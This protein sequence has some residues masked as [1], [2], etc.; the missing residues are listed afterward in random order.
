MSSPE[1]AVIRVLEVCSGT[2]SISKFCARYPGR[3]EVTS[4]DIAS[5]NGFKPTIK[6]DLLTWDFVKAVPV[7]YYHL[8][9]ASPPCTMFSAARTKASTP[10]DLNGADHMVQR[11]LNIIAHCRP[12]Y[13]FLE[14]PAT[15][16]L[17]CRTVVSGLK[18]HEVHYCQY[19]CPFKKPTM[20]WTNVPGWKPKLCPLVGCKQMIEGT[21]RHHATM[22]SQNK[23]LVEGQ[24]NLKNKW[25]I[26][27]IPPLMLHEL[28]NCVA[29]AEGWQPF[30]RPRKS[31]AH[32]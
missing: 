22:S 13:W 26:G 25:E 21:Q 15:G 18:G 7:G 10:R 28:W 5:V 14:N 20:I 30:A 1:P 29:H 27:K 19:D 24:S 4:V 8:V 3:F 6:T 31:K 11:C 32:P 17:P 16:M 9:W 23:Y 2:G 12:L